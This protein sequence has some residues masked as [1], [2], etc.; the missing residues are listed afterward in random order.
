MAR[1][2]EHP[3]KAPLTPKGGQQPSRASEDLEPAAVAISEHLQG[4]SMPPP[5]AAATTVAPTAFALAAKAAGEATRL[6]LQGKS[7]IKFAASAPGKQAPATR[8]EGGRRGSGG[9]GGGA[10]PTVSD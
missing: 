3:I 9:G 4:S 8:R 1:D 5:F 7:K 10:L 2:S 6:L